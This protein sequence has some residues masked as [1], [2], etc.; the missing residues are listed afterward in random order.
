MDTVRA[1]CFL[2]EAVVHVTELKPVG[3]YLFMDA[4]YACED[5]CAA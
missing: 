5:W 3:T 1:I 4:E 2:S